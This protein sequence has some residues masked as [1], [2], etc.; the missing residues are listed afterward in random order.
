MELT[1]IPMPLLLWWSCRS[2]K[3][4]TRHVITNP[5]DCKE[6]AIYVCAYKCA[7]RC[8][9]AKEFYSLCGGCVIDENDDRL[10]FTK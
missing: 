8:T 5:D 10:V 7:T 3:Q 2:C 9:I 6:K 1:E 4:T